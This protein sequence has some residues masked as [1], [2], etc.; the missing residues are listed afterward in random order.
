MIHATSS[1][2][3]PSLEPGTIHILKQPGILNN[4][5]ETLISNYGA[6]SLAALQKYKESGANPEKCHSKD[7][8]DHDIEQVPAAF[9]TQQQIKEGPRMQAWNQDSSE[10]LY[11]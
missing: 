3:R 1:I 5:L 2:L 7:L 9:K 8:I 10:Y 4:K 6:S 11:W